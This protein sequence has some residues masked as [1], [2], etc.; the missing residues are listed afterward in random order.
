MCPLY[1]IA[2]DNYEIRKIKFKGNKTFKKSELLDH[3]TIHEFNFIKKLQKKDPSLYSDDFIETDLERLKK[4]YQS[5]GFLHVEVKLDSL[6]VND[7][8]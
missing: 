1:L 6:D 3:L 5:E 7:E 2:Q 4:F 8:K